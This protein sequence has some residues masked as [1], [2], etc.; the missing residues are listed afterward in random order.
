M[1][2]N[3]TLRPPNK[4]DGM[5]VYWLI[6]QSPPLD[7]NSSYCN[8]LQCF[9][10][11]DTSVIAE[12]NNSVLG[13]ISGYRIPEKNDVLFIW[14]VAVSN[15]ARGQGLGK[16]M[17]R[18]L[19]NRTQCNY[20]NTSITEGNEASWN[21]FSSIADEFKTEKKRSTMFDRHRHFANQ[22]DTEYLLEIGPF[23]NIHTT[24]KQVKENENF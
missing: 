24:Q 2:I 23:R 21:L 12:K 14:Q 17:L 20:L 7:T 1:N 19:I 15:E 11:A 13:F 8:L 22:H 6:E 4:S 9:H 18:E 16:M 3:I 5:S 10:F